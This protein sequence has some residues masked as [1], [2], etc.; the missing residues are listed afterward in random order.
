MIF[1]SV[2]QNEED[3]KTKS[4]KKLVEKIMNP[5]KDNE[6]VAETRSRM[7]EKQKQKSSSN[8]ISEQSILHEYLKR[9]KPQTMI[10]NQCC[11]QNIVYPDPTDYGWVREDVL[12]PDWFENRDSIASIFNRF[13][14]LKCSKPCH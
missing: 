3:K 9:A 8:L 2:L 10:W 7:Y 1:S 14:S 13:I 11:E 4:F 5:G 6:S 12:K